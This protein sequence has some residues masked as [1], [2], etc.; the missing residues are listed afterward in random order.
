MA[1]DGAVLLHVIAGHNGEGLEA[2]AV[3]TGQGGVEEAERRARVLLV[4]R[5]DVVLDVRV[6]ALQ[7]V[8]V[9]VVVVAAF[10]DGQRDDVCVWV[11]HFR[12]HRFPIV[13]GEQVRVDAADYVG[14]AALG[15]SLDHR[16]QVV[17]RS[18]RVPHAGV[19]RLQAHAADGVVG[20][21]VV[22]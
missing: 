21:P 13:R 9:L 15:R 22:H 12:D 16:V 8:R 1:G 10:G 11:C 3:A 17:L 4:G 2:L 6:F 7:L 14:E 20:H 19:E 18:Q 5:V